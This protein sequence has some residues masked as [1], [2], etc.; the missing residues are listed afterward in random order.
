MPDARV[1]ITDDS[2]VIRRLLS[3]I[4]EEEPGLEVA[5]VA[6][7][8]RIALSKI[9][10]LAPDLVVM[11]IE[12]PEMNGLEALEELRKTHPSLPVV[13][14]STLTKRGASS[15]LDAL[16][17][18]ASDY[19]TKPDTGGGVTAAMEVVRGQ[20]V[21]K[22]RALCGQSPAKKSPPPPR[23]APRAA[24]TPRPMPRRT[25]GQPIHVVA[26]GISTGGP[27]ALM[28]MLPRLSSDLSV[29]VLIVQHMPP[30]F[31]RLL[32]ERLDA[33]CPLEVREAGDG[34]RFRSGE[35]WIAP[36][37]YH[38]TVA[39]DDGSPVLRLNQDPQENSCRPAAD[40]LFRSVVD[41]Y[42]ANS[43]ALVMTGMGQDGFRGAAHVRERGG[44]VLAQDETSSV[45]WGMPGFVA[46]EGLADEVL[47]LDDLPDAL[48]RWTRGTQSGKPSPA[49]T[50]TGGRTP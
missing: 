28:T 2:V 22:I 7:N 26:I 14:F 1:L 46:R 18:G 38:M 44:V 32:A 49:L 17:L 5:G 29:P 48:D 50:T 25:P 45:V 21:P 27:N 16:A 20:L 40:V 19:L 3:R 9:D 39:R 4:I 34:T 15:T 37:D 47:G 31:T 41:C 23:P 11:D 36:G 8:G 13:M 42:G 33:K 30:M 6:Q 24:A 12:M 43:L 35:V 10:R